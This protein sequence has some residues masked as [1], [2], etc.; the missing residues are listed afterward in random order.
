MKCLPQNQLNLSE[1]VYKVASSATA[2]REGDTLLAKITPCLENGKTGL[3]L[4]LK[5]EELARGS[6]EFIVM[7]ARTEGSICFSYCLA[8]DSK[9]R[10]YAIRSMSGSSGRQRV[11]LDRVKS[12]SIIDSSE[13]IKKFE[14]VASSSFQKIK[15][16]AQQI[17]TLTHLR[18]TLLPKLMKGEIRIRKEEF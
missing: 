11:P 4:D 12:Y 13:L 16:N 14:I 7:R 10:D 18:D 5:G 9:F 8:R 6:T 2:F 3:V 15:S 1:G 17:K